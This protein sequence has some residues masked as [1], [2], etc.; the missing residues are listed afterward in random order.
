MGGAPAQTGDSY[1]N[2]NFRKAFV[3]N[4]GGPSEVDQV[5]NV[6]LGGGVKSKPGLG[7]E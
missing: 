2:Q 4:F 5:N 1:S 3:P 6:I 7:G